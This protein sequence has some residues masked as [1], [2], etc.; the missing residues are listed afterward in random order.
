MVQRGK[1]G[2]PQAV[3]MHREGALGG[4]E[5]WKAMKE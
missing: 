4:G 3:L 5:G 1:L 2:L